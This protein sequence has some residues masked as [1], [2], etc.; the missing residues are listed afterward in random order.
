M[1]FGEETDFM[2]TELFKLPFP[3]SGRSHEEFRELDGRQCLLACHYAADGSKAVNLLFDG[4][5]AY[6]GTLYRACTVEMIRVANDRVVDLGPTPWLEEVS[7]QLSKH[8]EDNSGLRHLM[9]YFDDGP[10]YEFICRSF[11]AGQ[12]GES[13]PGRKE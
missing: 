12:L 8:G 4:I 9:F 13:V 7:T 11:Q 6:K 5:E 10:C 3:S 2:P 1:T